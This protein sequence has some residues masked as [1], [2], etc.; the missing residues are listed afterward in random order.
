MKNKRLRVRNM[1][2]VSDLDKLNPGVLKMIKTRADDDPDLKSKGR[3]DVT[4]VIQYLVS[5]FPNDQFVAIV[6]DHDVKRDKNDDPL[7]D[8]NSNEIPRKPHLHIGRK[9]KN[10]A[11]MNQFARAMGDSKELVETAQNVV[12]FEKVA[13]KAS[14]TSWENLV[15]YLFHQTKWSR[16]KGKFPYPFEWGA[17]NFDFKTLVQTATMAAQKAD[18]KKLRKKVNQKKLE[19]ENLA[20]ELLEDVR[21]GKVQLADMAYNDDLQR[22]YAKNKSQFENTSKIWID[23]VITFAGLRQEAI[24][25][26]DMKMKEAYESKLKELHAKVHSAD[27]YY[28]CGSAGSGKTF[29]AQRIGSFYDDENMPRGVYKA[30]GEEHQ[31]DEFNQ[32]YSVVMDDLRSDTYSPE[33]LLTLLDGNQFAKY[34]DARYKGSR[35]ADLRCLCLT[36]TNSLDEFV[37]YIPD[38]TN[39]GDAED[40]YF[41]RF[42]AVYVVGAPKV[43]DEDDVIVSYTKYKIVKKNGIG[44]AW[45]KGTTTRDVEIAKNNGSKP[46]QIFRKD[47]NDNYK[48]DHF[49]DY[50]LQKE[51]SMKMVVPISELDADIKPTDERKRVKAGLTQMNRQAELM[52]LGAHFGYPVDEELK[53]YSDEEV[54][55]VFLRDKKAVKERKEVMDKSASRQMW[56]NTLGELNGNKK[57]PKADKPLAVDNN[58]LPY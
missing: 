37:R 55:E 56:L 19:N 41:R 16:E 2:Y 26:N 18:L 44:K 36:N 4:Q 25:R 10:P 31:F 42:R 33:N 1:M 38:N 15:S 7:H 11:S 46:L 49:S 54:H 58:E 39:N 32:Q 22:A 35:T 50:F 52:I 13:R 20:D 5:Q 53:D 51:E 45:F 6:H 3:Y 12:K 14:N 28:I 34:L 24:V 57:Q 43:I 17:G 23:N 21:V 30:S 8:E 48:V 27:V 40:Q 29:L 9:S 47:E